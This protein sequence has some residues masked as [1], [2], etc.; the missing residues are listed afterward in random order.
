M[1]FVSEHFITVID[2]ARRYH[3][4]QNTMKIKGK[5]KSRK[6]IQEIILP[7]GSKYKNEIPSMYK[8]ITCLHEE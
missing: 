8:D 3:L 6:I 7:E 1:N 5:N 4:T 2:E